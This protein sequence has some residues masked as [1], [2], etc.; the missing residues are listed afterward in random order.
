MIIAFAN[1]KGGVGKTTSAV[2]LAA[3]LQ[4]TASTLLL[5]GDD[6]KGA[7]C[8]SSLLFQPDWTMMAC[9]SRSTLFAR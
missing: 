9:L 7:T 3:C 8:S 6:T 4:L 5:D 1:N 2:H